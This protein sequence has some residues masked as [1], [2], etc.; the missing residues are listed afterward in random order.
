MVGDN[1]GKPLISKRECMENVRPLSAV[2]MSQ[3]FSTLSSSDVSILITSLAGIL[4]IA[5][6][7]FACVWYAIRLYQ[8]IKKTT[9]EIKNKEDKDKTL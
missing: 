7:M 3:L 1:M 6:G 4:A 9:S 5:S 8:L 2:F